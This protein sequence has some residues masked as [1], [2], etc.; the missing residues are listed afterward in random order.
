[1][2]GVVAGLSVDERDPVA[3]RDRRGVRL[4]PIAYPFLA[5]LFGGALVWSF[6][7]I[8]LAVSDYTIKIGGL[9]ISGKAATA[10]IALLMALNVLIGAALVAYG[11]R[12]RPRPAS[13]PLLLAAGVPLVAGALT[14]T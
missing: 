12:V 10:A 4:P 9:H 8:L 7:R 14:P 2:A 13:Y 5:V 1:M 6:S 3:G 11:G